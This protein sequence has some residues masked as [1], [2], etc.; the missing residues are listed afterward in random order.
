M[1]TIYAIK[2]KV[3]N[4]LYIGRTH[5]KITDR[6][7]A[8]LSSLRSNR[9]TNKQ[10]QEDFN[11]YKEDNFEFY[12]IEKTEN[13]RREFYYMDKYNTCNNEYGY[14]YK[15]NHKNY[16]EIKIIQGLPIKN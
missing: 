11:K 3:N 9:H 16:N 13:K 14:N 10:L 5:R 15:D 1:Y 6:I 7:K 4:K 12:E 8:H 2:C